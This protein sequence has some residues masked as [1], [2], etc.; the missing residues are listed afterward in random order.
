MSNLKIG[1]K[2]LFGKY[3]TRQ[4]YWIKREKIKVPAYMKKTPVNI[5]KWNRKLN[6]WYRTGLFE[7]PI[8]LDK[9]FNLI[10][11]FSSAKIAYLKNVDVVPVYFANG[12]SDIATIK[13]IHKQSHS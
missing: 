2:R 12:G 11:G 1:I 3:E 5:R 4:L 10:D 8:I 6:Y 7:S 13:A 9:D